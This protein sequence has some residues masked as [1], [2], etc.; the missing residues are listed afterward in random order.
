MR[1][2]D[3]FTYS[4]ITCASAFPPFNSR[5]LQFAPNYPG[6]TDPA[7]VRHELRGRV[8]KRKAKGTGTVRGRITTFLCEN[9]VRTDRIVSRYKAKIS[10]TSATSVPLAGGGPVSTTGGLALTGKFKIVLGTGRFEGLRGRGRMIGQFTCLPGTLTRNSKQ[11]C[12]A[13]GGYSEAPFS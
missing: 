3:A 11:S 5:G 1:K 8:T 10:P 4:T 12:T 7:S 9:G 6:I 13:L 2:G